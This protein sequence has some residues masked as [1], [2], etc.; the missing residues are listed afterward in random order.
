MH[1]TRIFSGSNDSMKYLKKKRKYEMEIGM[2]FI[3]YLDVSRI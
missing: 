1:E 2:D 3:T